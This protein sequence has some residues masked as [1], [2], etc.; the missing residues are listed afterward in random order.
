MAGDAPRGSV[1]VAVLLLTL[2]LLALG[3][4]LA[5]LTRSELT[6]A[7]A[8]RDGAQAQYLAEAG[9]QHGLVKL[10]S[11]SDFAGSLQGALPAAGAYQ[12][13]VS[14]LGA[15]RKRLVAIG[16]QGA[17][18]RQLVVEVD[19]LLTAYQCAAAAAGEVQLG[20]RTQLTG[21]VSAGGLLHGAEGVFLDGPCLSA[22]PAVWE[23]G[24][25]QAG[26][27]LTGVSVPVPQ[28]PVAQ[29]QQAPGL[30]SA[31][32]VGGIYYQAGSLT[33]PPASQPSGYGELYVEG[34]L[35]VPAGFYL[36]GRWL[37][38]ASGSIVVGTGAVLPAAW[39]W[40]GRQLQ[41][42]DGCTVGGGSWSCGRIETGAQACLAYQQIGRAHV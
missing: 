17:E 39:L 22:V 38:A 35:Y 34:D 24:S 18:Q 2:L 8:A 10:A 27:C 36:P 37:L 25:L 14:D 23:P 16:V 1:L 41:L 42:G 30:T 12:V 9:I 13:L 19:M 4:T 28:P 6:T 15:G 33:L 5:G 7:V 32:L 31:G 20:P 21:A 29:H 3:S 26:S 40:A 11:Q